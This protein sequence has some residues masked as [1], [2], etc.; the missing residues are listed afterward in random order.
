MTDQVQDHG[1]RIRATILKSLKPGSG[2]ASLPRCFDTI[3][4]ACPLR[5]PTFGFPAAEFALRHVA[6]NILDEFALDPENKS[7]DRVPTSL[8]ILAVKRINFRRIFHAVPHAC[9]GKEIIPAG[10]WRCP[11]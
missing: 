4:A 11:S 10:P 7:S 2:P 8:E 1:D 3:F 9:F 6:R 5:V